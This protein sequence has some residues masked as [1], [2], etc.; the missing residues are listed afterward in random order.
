MG[1]M[2]DVQRD[3]PSVC[4]LVCFR[5]LITS[6]ARG[7]EEKPAGAGADWRASVQSGAAGVSVPLAVSRVPGL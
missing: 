2:L 7:A 4:F 5:P 1:W 6:E 3:Q